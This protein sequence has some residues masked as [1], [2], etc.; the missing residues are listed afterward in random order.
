MAQG[1]LTLD[2]G[3]MW[4]N[5]WNVVQSAPKVAGTFHSGNNTQEGDFGVQGLF[6]GLTWLGNVA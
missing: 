2:V 5:Y 3:W 4:V 1:D 6:F